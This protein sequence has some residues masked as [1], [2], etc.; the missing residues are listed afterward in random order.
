[1]D[2]RQGRNAREA[3]ECSCGWDFVSKQNQ[4]RALGGYLVE[5]GENWDEGGS[6]RSVGVAACQVVQLQS[7]PNR[8]TYGCE[9][10][11]LI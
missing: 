4:P 9:A 11:H 2:K 6:V 8:A 7:L 1:V 5:A 3:V 10:P